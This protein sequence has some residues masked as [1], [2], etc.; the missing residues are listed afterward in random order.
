MNNFILGVETIIIVYL[1]ALWIKGKVKD[2]AVTYYKQGYA[3]SQE[4]DTAQLLTVLKQVPY[5]YSNLI[6]KTLTKTEL[7][8]EE[9]KVNEKEPI[10]FHKS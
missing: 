5:E 3:K 8:K 7:P 1:L 9:E 10:G 4:E 2:F 6:W